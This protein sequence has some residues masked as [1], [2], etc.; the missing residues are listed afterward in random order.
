MIIKSLA[1]HEGDLELR[2]LNGIFSD[3]KRGL[4]IKALFHKSSDGTTFP[5][6][7]PFAMLP[8]LMPG[9]VVSN[10]EVL[11]ARKTGRHHQVVLADL[12]DADDLPVREAIPRSLYNLGGHTGG[13][14][15]ILR[16][17]TGD[18]TVFIPANELI[19]FLFLHSKVLAE[20][21]LR[22]SGLLDLA[23]TPSPGLCAQARIDFTE[24]ISRRLLMPDFVREFAWIS[25]HPD[26]RQAWDSVRRRSKDQRFLA[27]DPPPLHNCQL[28][29]RGVE[30]NRRWLVLEILNLSGRVLPA[31]T[32]LWS[33]PAECDRINEIIDGGGDGSDDNPPGEA[34]PNQRSENVVDTDEESRPNINKDLYL[35]G[36]KRGCFDNR[37]EV[38]KLLRSRQNPA[39]SSDS[40]SEGNGKRRRT[41]SNQSYPVN[42]DVPPVVVKQ[43]V[44]AGDPALSGGL[45]PVD[46]TTLD[47]AA[48]EP[49]RQ[50]GLLEE[51]LLRIED[52]QSDLTLTRRWLFLKPGKAVSFNKQRRRTCLVAVFTS[53][54]LPP[55]VVLDVDHG[56]LQGLA[57]L[58]LRYHAAYPLAMTDAH[59]KILLDALVDRHGHWS[60]EA[61]AKMQQF[62]KIKRL[63][64][65][66]R[67]T[68]R[69]AD[70]E[71]VDGWV[72][73]LGKDIFG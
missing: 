65:L 33:H 17:Q 31:S 15:R 37:A 66:A 6:D 9:L 35:L 7:L 26:G 72:K 11:T 21:L 43:F 56:D 12:S 13:D 39:P 22:P 50:L 14:Q 18:R 59:V 68:G 73:R 42:Q 38:V 62:V 34:R 2:W 46:F 20:A 47:E 5:T 63:P 61:A 71:Y 67:M 57:G 36:G 51:I 41:R 1:G 28:E 32:I 19:R 48:P 55:R 58:L 4:R 8:F 69:I 64:R 24:R 49:T 70:K 45:Q 25:I 60:H 53:P 3:F 54:S 10:G 44:S 29:F 40:H 27:F 23:V 16:Y 52:S 30:W